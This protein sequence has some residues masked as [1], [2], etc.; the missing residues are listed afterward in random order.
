MTKANQKLL[1]EFLKEEALAG[2][3]K[4]GLQ[5][6]QNR[7]P[8]FLNWLEDEKIPINSL[9]VRE[10][11]AYQG[12][13][14]ESGRQDGRRFA[15]H[16]IT[17]YVIAAG[18]FLEFAR[19]KHI[20][21]ANP[22]QEIRRLPQEK[23]LPRNLPREKNMFEFLETLID[24]DDRKHLK[25]QKTK[26]RIHLIAELMYSTGLRISEVAALKV[27]DLDFRR[28][29]VHV[30]EGKG[31]KPRVAYLN[32]F[33]TQILKLYIKRIRPYLMTLWNERNGD[34][35]FGVGEGW[36]LKQVNANLKTY[37]APLGCA[38]FT[39]HA[40]RHCLGWHLHRAGCNIRYIQEIMGHKYLRNTE[41]YTRVDKE[42]LRA[43]IDSHHPRGRSRK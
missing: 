4:Q 36:L 37:F 38:D 10:A 21:L 15:N 9:G 3:R 35:L 19:R 23:K 17:A 2:R 34:S 40:F 13:L 20:V 18:S 26:Y 31:G 24:W 25:H 5:S 8:K 43:I 39:S 27:Q 30:R 33:S 6:L 32:D 42:D 28:G 41:I 12:W 22:F 11:L 29:M 7:V 14:I 16:T 1:E